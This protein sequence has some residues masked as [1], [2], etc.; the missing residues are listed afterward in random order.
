M[1]TFLKFL[2]KEEVR[3]GQKR[4]RERDSIYVQYA[5]LLTS[6]TSLAPLEY[7]IV[8][9]MRYTLCHSL[10]VYS[11]KYNGTDIIT[12]WCKDCVKFTRKENRDRQPL[13]PT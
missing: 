1:P 10:A 5:D 8:F 12:I 3:K 2:T 9:G 6:L 7:F 13:Q 11:N 4:S